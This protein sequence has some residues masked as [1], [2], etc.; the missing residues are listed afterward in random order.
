M[1]LSP[2]RGDIVRA[3]ARHLPIEDE[4]AD[5]VVVDPPYSSHIEYSDDPRCI[6]KLDACGSKYYEAMREVAAEMFRVTRNRRYVALYC[7]DSFQKR[8]PFCPIG[9]ELFSILRSYFRPFDTI[10][11]VRHNAK[12]NRAQWHA[13][14]IKGNFFLRGFSYLFIMKKELPD[15]PR[16]GKGKGVAARAS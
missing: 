3:D 1:D 7:C 5:F 16:G 11:V 6:G 13:A 12:L 15:R 4:T 10:C 2:G 8:K 9:F 14:A